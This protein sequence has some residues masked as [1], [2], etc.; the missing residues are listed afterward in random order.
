[1]ASVGQEFCSGELWNQNLTWFTDSPDFTTCFHKTVLVYL[2]CA[3]LWLLSPFEVRANFVSSK[4]FVP[5]TFLNVAK[6]GSYCLLALISILEL[7]RFGL[8]KK[9]E[10]VDFEIEPA[11]FAGSG[12]KLATFLLATF[13]ILSGRR[14]GSFRNHM[15]SLYVTV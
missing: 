8:L 6:L 11:D 10:E 5:W 2:P 9:N 4:R 15:I 3:F 7:I 14:A 12:V 1:M 13:L